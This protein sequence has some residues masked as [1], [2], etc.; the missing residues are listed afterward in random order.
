MGY[1][2]R[3]IAGESIV[4]KKSRATEFVNLLRE[5]EKDMGHISWCATVQVYE[6]RYENDHEKITIAM[7]A[8]YGF[9]TDKDDN[10]LQLIGWGGDKIGSSWDGVWDALTQVVE[11]DVTWVMCGEDSE[12]WAER[13][14]GGKRETLSVDF[15][16]LLKIDAQL[17]K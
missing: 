6:T 15:D 3:H 7:M 14:S 9:I 17:K 13:L 12:I 4:I 8:D 16:A 2:A 11:H 10:S 1:S 5:A